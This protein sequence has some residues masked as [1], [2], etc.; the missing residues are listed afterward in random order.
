LRQMGSSQKGIFT[1]RMRHG[2]GQ[3]FMGTGIR[4]MTASAIFRM[5][6]PP[7]ILG[8]LAMWWGYVKSLLQRQPRFDDPLLVDFI[9]KYQWQCLLKGKNVATAELDKQQEQVWYARQISG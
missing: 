7:Y 5:M 9:R 2:F 8:G 4:Y 1:G 6:H 3:Y